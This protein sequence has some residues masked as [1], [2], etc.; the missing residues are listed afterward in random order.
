[1]TGSQK[2]ALGESIGVW[3]YKDRPSLEF[4]SSFINNCE[5]TVP[6]GA[7][8]TCI[9]DTERRGQWAWCDGLMVGPDDL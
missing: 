2:I 6:G 5:V 3:I 4:P 7:Q 8:E 1:M 9:F